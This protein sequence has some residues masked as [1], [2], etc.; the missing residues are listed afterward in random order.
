MA[1]MITDERGFTLLEIIIAAVV[2]ALMAGGTMLAFLMAVRL[3]KREVSNES[4]AAFY[5]QQTLERFRN[6]IACDDDWFSSN[7]NCTGSAQAQ[8][9]DP[10]PPGSPI[11][12][13]PPASRHYTFQPEDCD[14]DGVPG[15]CYRMTAKVCWNEPGC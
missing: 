1:A 11:L 14:G 8:I 15:D 12:R 5:A 10:I 2:A 4:E 9:D 13:L 3:S 7:P 6:R